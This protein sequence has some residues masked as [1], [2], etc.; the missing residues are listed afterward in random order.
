MGSVEEA[1]QQGRL[2]KT[3]KEEA[4]RETKKSTSL[5]CNVRGRMAVN[6]LRW[7]WKPF[8]RSLTHSSAVLFFLGS[9]LVASVIGIAFFW[10]VISSFQRPDAKGC[11]PDGEGSWSIGIYYGKDPFSLVPIELVRLFIFFLCLN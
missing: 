6:R 11:Q 7:R 5:L 10:L 1:S 2:Q 9:A 8:L 4:S 3:E